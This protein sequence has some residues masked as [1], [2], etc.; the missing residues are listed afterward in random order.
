M[1]IEDVQSDGICLM[2]SKVSET[3]RT[4]EL[5]ESNSRVNHQHLSHVPSIG[6]MFA[7]MSS[8]PD[9]VGSWG[10]SYPSADL[11]LQWIELQNSQS[12]VARRKRLNWCVAGPGALILG[13]L[14]LG[15]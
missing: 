6:T 13:G 10:D 2:C 15:L 7:R 9:G 12:V 14:L 3:C 5:Q 8:L 1:K 11:A 4:A